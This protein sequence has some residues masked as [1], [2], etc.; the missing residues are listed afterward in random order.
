MAAE[1]D[2]RRCDD[3]L[4]RVKEI[5]KRWFNGITMGVESGDTRPIDAMDPVATL[6]INAM[7]IPSGRRQCC[8]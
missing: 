1:H 8:R 4:G 2:V 6:D 7:P 3:V 5:D